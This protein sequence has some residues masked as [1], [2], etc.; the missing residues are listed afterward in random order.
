MAIKVH[1]H[2]L[3]EIREN[4]NFTRPEVADALGWKT[5]RVTHMED[6]S[7]GTTESTVSYT[8]ALCD[9][10]QV[11]RTTIINYD[12]RPTKVITFASGKGGTG[13]TTTCCEVIWHLAKTKKVLAIDGDPQGNLS[14]MLGFSKIEEQN[15]F[16]LLSTEEKD[17]PSININ[18]FVSKSRLNN[19]DAITF[20]PGM[21]IAD[22][23][24]N[25]GRMPLGIFRRMKESLVSEGVYDY[26]I[27][28]TSFQ[29]STYILGLIIMADKFY[30]PL[31][32]APFTIDALPTFFEALLDAKVYKQQL[33]SN[34]TFE[35]DGI[36]R[37]RV[38]MRKVIAKEVDS[39]LKQ[40]VP[41]PVLEEFIPNF[42][43]LE[44]AQ[45]AGRF[46]EEFDA[47]SPNAKKIIKAYERIAKEVIK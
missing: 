35:V 40:Y 9:Y 29:I 26:V 37:T 10:Y 38:D 15:L 2:K 43:A 5:E 16:T 23:K 6:G 44:Q 46:I 1:Y 13:K 20:N 36:I 19:V 18:D 8:E 31:D 42:T 34:E 22:R 7:T 24:L 41:Y 28:D 30:V 12:Y 27:I 17:V 39:Y 14:K 45:Y 33:W 4:L 11:P 3:R 21:Y 25:M 32:L 47:S